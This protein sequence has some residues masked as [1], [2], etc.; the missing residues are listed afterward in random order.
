MKIKQTLGT[1]ILAGTIGIGLTGCKEVKKEISNVLHEDAIVITKIYTP[2]RHDT[3]IELKAM[4][5]VGEGAGSI[6]MDYDGD[7]GI[8]IEDGLQISF[9]EVPEKYGV[10]F[11]CQHGTFTSQGS[12]ERHKELYRKLQNNQEVDVTY[13]EI[14]RTTYDDIDGDGKRDLVEKVL[15]GFDFLDANPKEE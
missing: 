4:N 12:D 15:T 13:K 8:G 11:K 9:S 2:S 5:L 7:L 1:I 3:D 6:S 10:V 14:Y